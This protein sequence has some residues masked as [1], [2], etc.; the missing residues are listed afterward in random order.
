MSEVNELLQPIMK[1]H[2][3]QT[4]QLQ[5]QPS[6]TRGVSTHV[7]LDRRPQDTDTEQLQVLFVPTRG[8]RTRTRS[9]CR[10]YLSPHAASGHGHGAAAGP[11][12]PH[13]RP[14]DTDTEQLQ[15]LFVP[16]RGLRTRTRSSCRS[17]LS[18]HA[19]SGHGHGAAAGPICPHTRPQ[20]TDTEQLQVLFVPT[21]GLRTR[22]RSSCRSYLSPHAASG[23][24]HGAAAGPLGSTLHL[25]KLWSRALQR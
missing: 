2:K 14:Q 1:P 17:Y 6:E 18:P 5:G 15:V 7:P 10:S 11:I 20:D 24:G 9:S 19:A 4:F 8:L 13:T 16:T 3:E 25:L 21:R 12:C 23:H 22:T